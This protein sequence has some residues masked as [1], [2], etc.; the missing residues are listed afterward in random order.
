MFLLACTKADEQATR[1]V[2]E[3]DYTE[4]PRDNCQLLELM[5]STKP[6]KKE[7]VIDINKRVIALGGNAVYFN[8]GRIEL[9]PDTQEVDSFTNQAVAYQCKW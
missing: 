6:S 4:K 2:V 5:T 8:G 7:T 9:D 3:L 1:Q